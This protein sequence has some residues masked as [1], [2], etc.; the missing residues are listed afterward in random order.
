LT[1]AV[2][3]REDEIWESFSVDSGGGI[4]LFLITHL[5][6]SDFRLPPGNQIDV[7]SGRISLAEKVPEKREVHRFDFYS[8]PIKG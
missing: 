1:T 5:P 3:I 4:P 6:G 2:I 8:P 7:S